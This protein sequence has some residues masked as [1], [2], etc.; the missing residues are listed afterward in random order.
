MSRSPSSSNNSTTLSTKR[1]AEIEQVLT[2]EQRTEI[3]RL[4]SERKARR[5]EDSS[6]DAAPNGG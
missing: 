5:A 3:A 4:K 1:D 6:N 2:D